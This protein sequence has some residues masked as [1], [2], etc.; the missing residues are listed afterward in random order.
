VTV[1]ER[2]FPSVRRRRPDEVGESSDGCRTSRLVLGTTLAGD[3]RPRR[4]STVSAP[5]TGRHQQGQGHDRPGHVPEHRQ[6]AVSR[7]ERPFAGRVVL[8][9]QHSKGRVQERRPR[10]SRRLAESRESTSRT[11]TTPSRPEPPRFNSA[12]GTSVPHSAACSARRVTG[13]VEMRATDCAA[14]GPTYRAQPGKRSR[15]VSASRSN[16]CL[17]SAGSCGKSVTAAYPVTSP[18]LTLIALPKEP[19][20]V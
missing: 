9:R 7:P 11:S 8:T 12:R 20:W 2:T 10:Q 19:N 3:P 16:I 5:A 13:S 17:R 4:G 15:S 6:R 1:D 18:V 14:G